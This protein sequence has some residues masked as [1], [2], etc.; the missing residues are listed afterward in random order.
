LAARALPGAAATTASLV[1]VKAGGSPC[2]RFDCSSRHQR[3][4]ALTWRRHVKNASEA[5]R[6]QRLYSFWTLKTR[7]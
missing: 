6:A 5:P 1:S 2:A 3:R 4:A 7:R